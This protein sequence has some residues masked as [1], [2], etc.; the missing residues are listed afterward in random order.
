MLRLPLLT[1]TGLWV[2]A[3]I[4][5]CF[6]VVAEEIPSKTKAWQKFTGCEW[7]AA[8]AND[9]DSFKVKVAGE[10]RFLR[11]TF[12]D[13]PE[14]DERFMTR[15]EEQAR[16]FGIPV[17]EVKR[18][19]HEAS[20]VTARLLAQPFTVWTRWASAA[21]STRLPRFYAFIELSD[22]RDLNEVLIASGVAWVKG[23]AMN[24]PKG[25]KMND[26]RARLKALEAETRARRIGIW[27]RT[28]RA[29]SAT[30]PSHPVP[31]DTQSRAVTQRKRKNP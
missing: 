20:A 18:A 17:T 3:L 10:A 24:T 14:V 25:E 8:A 6:V 26:Y 1:S 4:W 13:T 11:L 31:A 28:T 5:Q 7:V 23:T 12:V 22:G 2:A 29:G 27:A 15:N 30:S 19:G 9:G 21:G 16:H